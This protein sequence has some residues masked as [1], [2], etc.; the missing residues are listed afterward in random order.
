MDI[1]FYTCFVL[2]ICAFALGVGLLISTW[3]VYFPDISEMYQLCS[4]LGCLNPSYVP[5]GFTRSIHVY[6]TTLNPMYH[7]VK[8]FRILYIMDVYQRR[9]VSCTVI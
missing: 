2:I 6:I 4:L 5:D 9:G 3:A 1:S 7:M 8:L